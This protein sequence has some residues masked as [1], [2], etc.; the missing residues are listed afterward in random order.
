MKCSREHDS[1]E[2]K[3]WILILKSIYFYVI[4]FECSTS[5]LLIRK[6]RIFCVVLSI[7]LGDQYD[8]S[9]IIDTTKQLFTINLVLFI[10]NDVHTYYKQERKQKNVQCYFTSSYFNF[11]N[12]LAV[13]SFFQLGFSHSQFS[14]IRYIFWY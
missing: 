2:F 7:Q 9:A 14:V 3:N 10:I 12:K 6:S 8:R 11:I 1:Y 13:I 5:Q 4:F